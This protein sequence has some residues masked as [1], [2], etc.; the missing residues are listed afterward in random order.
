MSDKPK[1][2]LPC[3]WT[4]DVDGNWDTDCDNRFVLTDGTPGDNKMRF[5]CYCGRVLKQREYGA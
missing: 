2:E 4:E 3:R 1:S 5:C